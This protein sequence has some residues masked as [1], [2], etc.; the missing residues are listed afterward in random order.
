MT[1]LAGSRDAITH[2]LSSAP[3]IPSL[4]SFISIT[5]S[6][7]NGEACEAVLS[8]AYSRIRRLLLGFQVVS[9]VGQQCSTMLFDRASFRR[10]ILPLR[11]S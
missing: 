4:N 7:G 10:M 3:N 1:S 5:L 9:V 11:E 6:H 8:T 2:A